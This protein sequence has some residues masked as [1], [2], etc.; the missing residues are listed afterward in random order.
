LS[1]DAERRSRL[2]SLTLRTLVRD[3]VG[4]VDDHAPTPEMFAPGALLES[5]G[6]TWAL[7]DGDPVHSLGAVLARA[8]RRDLPLHVI[9]EKNSGIIA[10][11]ASLFD[12]GVSVWHVDDRQLFP[13]V[14][15]P[16]LPERRP[17]PAHLALAPVI[18]SAGADVVVE[19]GVVAG[20]VRGLEMCRVV[21]DPVTGA[22]RV[23][24]GMGAHDRET[25]AM[26]HGDEPVDA[27]LRRV[28]GAV[29]DHRRE[30]AD[31]HPF[32]RFGAERLLR[33]TATQDPGRIGFSAL[34]PSEPPVE[35]TNVKD[36]VP[37]VATGRTADG[38]R[39]C[40]VFVHGVVLDAVPFA[41][42]AADR[43]GLS[44]VT[45]AMRRRDVVASHGRM[46]ERSRVRVR[47][48]LLDD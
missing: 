44:S 3:H 41:V 20:E 17:D 24:V 45:L 22:A 11:R 5:H 33:W 19:H 34:A 9:V 26:V 27:A 32:N 35:R 30:G 7:I 31:P 43:A 25:F 13:A 48:A 39:G 6:A 42:D 47:F 12:L 16:H 40:A 1:A 10:R 21:D 15:E 23:E 28:I 36:A 29:A 38:D 37:C 46:A 14:P 4:D 8:L 2:L 18:E